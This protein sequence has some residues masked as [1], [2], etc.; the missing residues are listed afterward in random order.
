MEQ[1]SVIGFVNIHGSNLLAHNCL[2]ILHQEIFFFAQCFDRICDLM[3]RV[4]CYR[5][6]D[7]G[8]DSR[9]YQIFGELVGLER[10]LLRIVNVTEEI[11]EWKNSGSGS[12]NSKLTAV[13]IRR[14]DNA[15]PSIRK[16]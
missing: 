15:T 4:P 9:R 1:I 16:S 2:L 12:R 14:S 6:R 8:F 11:L 5:S 7:P 10:G 3:I 13:G